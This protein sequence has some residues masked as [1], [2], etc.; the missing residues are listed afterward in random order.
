MYFLGKLE[1]FYNVLKKVANK[2]FFV[3]VN[4]RWSW[5]VFFFHSFFTR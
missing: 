5:R 3:V 1:T 2:A 4:N